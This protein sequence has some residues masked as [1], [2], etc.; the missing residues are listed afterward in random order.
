LSSRQIKTQSSGGPDSELPTPRHFFASDDTALLSDV[1]VF[2]ESAPPSSLWREAGRKLVRQPKFIVSVLL[3]AVILLAVAWPTLFTKVPKN[4]CDLSKSLDGPSAGHPLGFEKL[5]CDIFSRVVNGARPSVS[6]GVLTT[7]LVVIIGG[8]IGALAGWYGK[9]VDAL[10]SRI[11]DIFFALPLVLAAIVFLQAFGQRGG[12]LGVFSVVAVMAAFGW[13]QMARITR[14]AVLA[15]KNSDFV[16]AAKAIGVSRGKILLKHAMPNAAAPMIVTATVSLGTYIVAEAT[17][18]FLG[19]GLPITTRSWGWQI[20][21]AK[22]MLR[23]A[24]EVLLWP[25]AALALT[26]L[27]FIMLGDAVRDALDPKA[28][29]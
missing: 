25:A 5:G 11:T 27:A 3:I 22:T 2:D 26:V 16:T 14:S 21:D 24:P 4:S 23:T 19:V 6:V 13:P 18:S 1:D 17:L 10:L 15:V 7:L 20:S 9:W 29:R 12:F 28:R 8:L